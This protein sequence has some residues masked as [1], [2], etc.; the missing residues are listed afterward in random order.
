MTGET[1]PFRTRFLAAAAAAVLVAAPA[2]PGDTVHA[3][4]R[5]GERLRLLELR[6][7]GEAVLIPLLACGS[8][9]GG[10]ASWNPAAGTWELTGEKVAVKGF[11]DEPLLLVGGQ[12]VLV[13]HPPRL[14]DGNPWLSLETVRMLGRHGWEVEVVWNEELK[15][16]EVRAFQLQ[17]AAETEATRSGL[18]VPEVPRGSRVI[19]LD[20]GHVRSAG[21]RG[22]GGLTE[23]DLGLK[24]AAAVS[25]SLAE[26]G[27]TPVILQGEKEELDPREAAGIA[28]ALGAE[29]FVSF[30]ASEY[31][32][33][34]PVVW[35][36]GLANILGKTGVSFSPFEPGGGWAHAAGD[37]AAASEA[38][39]QKLVA[40]LRT[41]GLSADGPFPAPLVALEG[42][43][44]PAV[45]VSLDGF[46]TLEGASV[47]IESA[48]IELLAGIVAETLREELGAPSRP[49]TSAE[50]EE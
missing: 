10:K 13:K 50:E 15:E 9:L 19:V 22:Y 49:E 2:F 23:G 39:S 40:R 48:T 26:D 45:V 27:F 32:G 30:H 36:W 20:T 44:C 29:F 47:A 24:I 3:T 46:A 18:A 17:Q 21:A 25:A 16:M 35:Y 6:I 34:G 41:G 4:V 33:P 11:L 1:R 14:I 5:L 43:G 12:P 28:N 42:I 31:G 7:D 37:H 8:L 38:A